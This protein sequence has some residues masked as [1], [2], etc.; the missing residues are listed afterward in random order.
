MKKLI[1]ILLLFIY[2]CT[3]VKTIPKETTGNSRA[4]ETERVAPNFYFR[5]NGAYSNATVPVPAVFLLSDTTSLQGGIPFKGGIV[6][7]GVF[8]L[9]GFILYGDSK[10]GQ[11]VTLRYLDGNKQ[12]LDQKFYVWVVTERK[13]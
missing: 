4:A 3:P 1:T 10:M 6:N 13:K 12:P 5:I 11:P 7:S 8:A 9:N 2:S